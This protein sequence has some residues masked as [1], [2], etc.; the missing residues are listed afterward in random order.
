MANV[1][2][3]ALGA[4]QAVGWTDALLYRDGAANTIAQR[5]ST[6]AQTLN[7]YGSYTNSTTYS[8]LRINVSSTYVA[9]YAENGSGGG[10]EQDFYFGTNDN[11]N[12]Y[13]VQ[14]GSN[15]W[16]IVSTTAD[17]I[18]VASGSRNFGGT[19][20]L[21]KVIHTQSIYADLTTTDDGFINFNATVD[22]DTTSAISSLTTS[23]AVTHHIQVEINGTKAWIPASTNAPS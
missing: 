6:N 10:T 21:L 19:A 7:I 20:A 16:R 14:N 23:G 11:K 17:L 22:A 12:I 15:M 18:P 2:I 8:R 5:N 1:E 9:L 3:D 13:I 4:T